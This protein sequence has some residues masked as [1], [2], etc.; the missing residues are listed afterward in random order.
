MLVFCKHIHTCCLYS[1]QFLEIFKRPHIPSTVWNKIVH[2]LHKDFSSLEIIRLELLHPL[3]AWLHSLLIDIKR[4]ILS[5]LKNDDSLIYL[6]KLFFY[7]G[8]ISFELFHFFSS[9]WLHSLRIDIESENA[10]HAPRQSLVFIQSLVCR[11]LQTLRV[12]H[13]AVHCSQHIPTDDAGIYNNL[14]LSY[15]ILGLL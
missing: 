14:S 6:N 8:A 7:F 3:L 5:M 9:A 15:T 2:L 12:L 4:K 10:V 11:R 13:Y 1:Q